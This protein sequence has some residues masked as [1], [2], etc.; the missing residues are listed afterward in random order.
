MSGT[1]DQMLATK[2]SMNSDD[3][4][5]CR[6]PWSSVLITVTCIWWAV[7]L[8]GLRQS[9]SLQAL[10][11]RFSAT[12]NKP[13]HLFGDSFRGGDSGKSFKNRL[14]LGS[15]VPEVGQVICG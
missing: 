7:Y 10:M 13:H 11:R 6:K 2:V 9:Y 12:A 1:T 3:I 14:C 8:S 4:W 5:I 15:F